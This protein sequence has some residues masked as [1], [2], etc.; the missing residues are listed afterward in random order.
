[1]PITVKDEIYQAL[2]RQGV[3]LLSDPKLPSLVSLV[4]GEP[5]TGSWWGHPKG[6]M[7]YAM[8]EELEHE[9]SVMT[10][11][12]VSGKTT[13]VHKRLWSYIVCVG[14]AKAVW[15]V[16]HLSGAAVG[17]FDLLSKS[18]SL[19]INSLG[20]L[21]DGSKPG[22]ACDELEKKLLIFAAQPDS[23]EGSHAKHV[24]TW[25]HWC[26]RNSFKPTTQSVDDAM[27]ELE[28]VLYELNTKYGALA[29]LPWQDIS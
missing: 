19:S 23:E 2:E 15:Q 26:R 13:F 28:G 1:M 20:A 9:E 5:V 8:A 29:K 25:E 6:P 17:F 3:L 11:K 21:P 16:R 14:S 12:L 22:K 24:E 18:G 27:A 4:A 7:I 10:T